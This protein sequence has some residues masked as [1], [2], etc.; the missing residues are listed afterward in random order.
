MA[1]AKDIVS[2]L[3]ECIDK[4]TVYGGNLEVHDKAALVPSFTS[5]P[6]HV[7][8]ST[9]EPSLLNFIYCRYCVDDSV[10]CLE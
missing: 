10:S 2:G 5:I 8:E 6:N 3:G 9:P 4:K 1:D 7:I